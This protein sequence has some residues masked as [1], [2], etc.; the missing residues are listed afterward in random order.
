M[1]LDPMF[2]EVVAL[3]YVV[4]ITEYHNSHK[5]SPLTTFI[6]MYV[7]ASFICISCNCKCIPHLYFLYVHLLYVFLVHASL[8][9][10]SCTYIPHMYLMYMHLSCILYTVHA[11]FMSCATVTS[12][13]VFRGHYRIVINGV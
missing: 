7:P 2:V 5:H 12:H 4:L 6:C 11:S 10:I 1:V 13:R 9:C 8:I 3:R